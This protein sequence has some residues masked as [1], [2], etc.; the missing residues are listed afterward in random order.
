M[1][2]RWGMKTSLTTC[3][4]CLAFTH[5]SHSFAICHRI[6]P[7]AAPHWCAVQQLSQDNMVEIIFIL[8]DH[9][10]NVNL[11]ITVRSGC[12]KC[13]LKVEW[14]L[15]WYRS[16][17]MGWTLGSSRDWTFVKFSCSSLKLFLKQYYCPSG[18]MGG[19]LSWPSHTCA[20]M[21]SALDHFGMKGLIQDLLRIIH[22]RYK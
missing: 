22:I 18:S 5:Y 19:R 9:P 14:L 1:F 15:H 7:F 16:Q 21:I 6:F 3:T 8:W 2:I 20:W 11:Q 12:A 17:D 10:A 13:Y 4:G